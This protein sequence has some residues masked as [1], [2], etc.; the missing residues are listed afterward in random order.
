MALDENTPLPRFRRDLALYRGPDDADGSPTY[1]LFDPIKGQYYKI[2][3]EE[4]LILQ[5]FRSGMTL[6]QLCSEVSA[7]TTLKMTPDEVKFFFEDAIRYNLLDIRK[8]SEQVQKEADRTRLGFIKTF[9]YKYL[10]FRIPI[11][12]PNEFLQR[13]LRY[14]LPFISPV[15]LG[16]YL[17]I[18][19]LGILMLIQRFDEYVHTFTYFFNINGML[20]YIFGIMLV[21]LAHE[22][23][24]AYAASY[25]KIH[26]SSMGIAVMISWPVLYTDVTDA[27]KLSKRNQRIAISAAGITAELIL[28]GLCTFGWAVTQPGALQSIFFVVSS[29]TW[30]SSLIVNMNPAMRF[31]GYYLL[32]DLLGLDNLQ[33]RSFAMTRWWM[34]RHL[35]GLNLPSPEQKL[36]KKMGTIML[37][38]TIYTWVYRIFLYTAIAL[39][40]YFFFTKVLG[41]FLFIAE[42]SIFIIWPITSEIAE[43]SRFKN[44]FKANPN[45][46][47]L[48]T[49]CSVV[50]MYLILPLPHKE[51]FTATVIPFEEQMLYVPQEAMVEKINVQRKDKVKKGDVLVQLVSK[52]LDAEIEGFE[53]SRQVVERELFQVGLSEKYRSYLGEKREEYD[54]ILSQLARLKAQ[55]ENLAIRAEIDGIVIAW[56]D[57]LKPNQYVSRG[58]L[59]GKIADDSEIQFIAFVPENLLDTIKVGQEA[60]FISNKSHERYQATIERIYPT[61]NT[62]LRYPQLS[63]TNRGPL[64]VQLDPAQPSEK[65]LRLL[66]S[67]YPIVAVLKQPEK[68]LRF[69]DEGQL[70]VEGPWRSYLGSLIQYIL[71]IFWQES[72][73]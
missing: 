38:Y 61:R 41:I 31:D 63:S 27:W 50:L 58:V 51:H 65:Q 24:H 44:Y 52:K 67:Y 32:S 15:A 46:V 71:R 49:I 28:A 59:L 60:K 16:V 36:S 21:K 11:L 70:E 68:K 8:P 1:N 3:W 73:F 4:S 13:T 20:A 7:N 35:F 14:A 22:F 39:F 66:E 34:R 29:I 48:I 62:Y 2:S 5:I 33:T 72:G 37:V 12:K 45:L 23:A 42:I 64:P 10:Y 47:A 53:I 43:T 57:K 25:F 40:V 30:V 6:K 54:S 9:L 69:G 26:V 55:K 17:F 19:V 56:D 18:S